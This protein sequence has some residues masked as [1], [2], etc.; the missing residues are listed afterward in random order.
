[1]LYTTPYQGIWFQTKNLQIATYI[2]IEHF[3][4]KSGFEFSITYLNSVHGKIGFVNS[5]FLS[6]K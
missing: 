3:G 1:M 2:S 4:V 6:G 5:R